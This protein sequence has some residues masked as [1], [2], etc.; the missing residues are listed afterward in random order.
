LV[1][2]PFFAVIDNSME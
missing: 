2:P 1:S